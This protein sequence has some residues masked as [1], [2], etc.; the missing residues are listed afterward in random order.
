MTVDEVQ[1]ELANRRENPYGEPTEEWAD[2]LDGI[3]TG[4][5]T[6]ITK[7][8]EWNERDSEAVVKVKQRL[9]REGKRKAR[10]DIE[11]WEM[12]MIETCR[13]RKFRKRFGGRVRA[14]EAVAWG[15]EGVEKELMRICRE[16]LVVLKEVLVRMSGEER[17]GDDL[18]EKMRVATNGGGGGM[19]REIFGVLRSGDSGGPAALGF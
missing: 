4:T 12:M 16:K 5:V 1:R 3:Q 7:V 17:K 18:L 14:F 15:A 19:M 6:A 8:M 11:W 10:A 2:I 9:S 13:P